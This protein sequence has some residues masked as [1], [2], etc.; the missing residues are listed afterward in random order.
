MLIFSARTILSEYRR[1]LEANINKTN[2][3]KEEQY[4]ERRRTDERNSKPLQF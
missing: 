3:N 4:T 2:W 1:R